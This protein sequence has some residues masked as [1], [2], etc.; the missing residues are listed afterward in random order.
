[1]MRSCLVSFRA[2]LFAM[3]MFNLDLKLL[4]L[5]L[6]KDLV[7]LNK[8]SILKCSFHLGAMVLLFWVI[9]NQFYIWSFTEQ[10]LDGYN[11]DGLMITQG[12]CYQIIL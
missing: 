9:T 11:V 10:K 3:Q 12:Q 7:A 1:M 5:R 8:Y 4:P 2:W 6:F